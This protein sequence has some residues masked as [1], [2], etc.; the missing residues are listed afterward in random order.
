MENF[1]NKV[2]VRIRHYI[3][4]WGVA[5]GWINH[6]DGQYYYVDYGHGRVYYLAPDKE[7]SADKIP[8]EIL[9]KWPKESPAK[10]VR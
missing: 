1:D 9:E 2:A 5:D 6:A 10:G 4:G 7:M 3:Y 8:P